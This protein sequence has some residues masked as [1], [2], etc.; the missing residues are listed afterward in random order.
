MMKPC[1]VVALAVLAVAASSLGRDAAATARSRNHA[2]PARRA[3]AGTFAA[4]Q[5]T[6][7]PRPSDAPPGSAV[8]VEAPNPYQLYNDY[9]TPEQRHASARVVVHFV[10]TGVN[11]PPLNDD[12]DDRV[13]DYVE[14]VGEAAD[15][16]IGYYQQRGFRAIRAD[17]G[18]SDA[19]PD[20][21]V[22]RFT[23]GT[24]GVAFAEERAEGGA[25]VVVANNL[26]PSRG[27]SFVSLQG[28]VAHELFHLVQFSYYP[29]DVDPPISSWVL[30]G[31]AVALEGRVFPEMSDVVWEL[32]LEPWLAAPNRTMTTKTYSSWLF[33][34]DLDLHAPEVLP[35]YLA[36]RAA[37]DGST[38]LVGTY[39]RVTGRSFAHAFHR[40]AV[41]AGDDYG[42]ALTPQRILSRGSR[43][44]R[45]SIARLAAHYLR[46]ATGGN[47]PRSLVVRLHRPGALAVTL[48]YQLESETPGEPARPLRIPARATNGGQTLTYQ[49]PARLR[50]ANRYQQPTLIVSNGSAKNPGPYTITVGQ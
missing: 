5:A 31:T 25:F 30:E 45:A 12:D 34:R 39:A 18:G 13:P 16:A 32:Q 40:F 27:E 19:R 2:P 35:A 47:G 11:A 24:F 3:T 50:T 49:I 10:V 9:A 43:A 46:L 17:T 37:G 29:V 38:A 6:R 4:F 21:Y 26:D 44:F 20:I 8:T 23:P 41:T 42:R 15:A 48:S 22:S 7:R 33:W 14:R 1:A 36:R 28:T